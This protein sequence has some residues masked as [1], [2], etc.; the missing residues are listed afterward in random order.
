M[1]MLIRIAIMMVLVQVQMQLRQFLH[2]LSNT[3][4]ADLC[5]IQVK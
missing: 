5:A 4:P 2:Q 1:V 3:I